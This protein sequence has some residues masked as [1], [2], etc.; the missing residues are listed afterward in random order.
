[1]MIRRL[2]QTS[3]AVLLVAALTGIPSG[4]A[5]LEGET[6]SVALAKREQA[7]RANNLGVA[8]L[9]QFRHKEAAEAFSR[10]LGTDPTLALARINLAI[11]LFNVPDMEAAERGALA[12]IEVAPDAPQAHYVVGLI[13]RQQGKIEEAKAAFQKVLTIDPR[14]V[15]ALVNLGQVQLR[16]RQYEEAVAAFRAAAAA[17]PYNRTAVYNLG[18]ALSRTGSKEESREVMARFLELRKGGYGTEIGRSYPEQGRYAEA[19]TSTGAEPTL[20]DQTT[21]AAR[22]VEAA[23]GALPEHEAPDLAFASAF[24]RQVEAGTAPERVKHDLAAA[25]GGQV[26][27]FDHDGDG[28]LDLF[29]VDARGQ[30]LLR[31]ASGRFS[32]VTRASGLDPS[33]GGIGAVA[34]DHDNDG[35]PDLLVLR[36]GGSTLHRNGDDGRFSDVTAAAG[37][38]PQAGLVVSAAFTDVDHDGDLDIFLAGLASLQRPR[39]R[40]PDDFEATPN[41]L[42]LNDGAGVFTEVAA[43]MGLAG[44]ESHVVA[45]VPM[46]FDNRRDIDLLTVPYGAAPRLF[47]NLRDGTFR[48]VAAEVGLETSARFRC[49]AAADV[50]KDGFTDLF[51]GATEGPDFLALSDGKGRFVMVPAPEGSSGTTAALLLDY[52]NDG[53]LDLLTLSSGGARLL[54]NL[55]AKWVDVSAQALPERTRVPPETSLAAGDIDGDGDTDVVLRFRSGTLRI[56]EN[57]GGNKNPSLRVRIAGRISNR[58]GVGAKVEVRAGSLL[59]RL[60]TYAA[61]PAPAPADIVLG[62]GRRQGADAVRV[63]WPAGILQTELVSGEEAKA[64]SRASLTGPATAR[65]MVVEE[66]DR[67][68]S[69][70]PYLY[71]WNG[72]RFEFVTDFMGGGEIGYWQGPG[73]WSQ[74]DPDEYVRL[75]PGQLSPRDGRFEIRVTNELEEATFLDRVALVVV[76]HPADAQVF[77]NE[78]LTGPP[79]SP[80]RLHVALGARP[81]VSATDHAGRDV[82]DRLTSLDRRYV[83][84]LPVRRVRGYADEHRLTLDLGTAEAGRDLLLLTGWTDYAFSSDNVAAH[85]TGHHL[86]PPTIEVQDAAGQ[87]QAVGTAGIPVGRP[88]TVP[89]DLSGKWLGPGRMVR[90]TTNMRIYWDQILAARPGEPGRAVE[91]TT[92]E[93]SFAELRERGFSLELS[94]DGREPFG[95]DYERATWHSPWKTMPGRYTRLGDVRELLLSSDDMFVISRPGDEVALSFETAALRPLP[96]G[97]ERT[98]LVYADGFSKEMDINSATPHA[99]EPLPFHGMTGYPYTAPEVF[100]WTPERL[101]YMERYNTRV[102]TD[103]LPSLDLA[104]ARARE[105]EVERP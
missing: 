72:Q 81:P 16:E 87:W 8:L 20:V 71:T 64:P 36:P 90:I 11:A 92:L 31:N 38:P 25:L 75:R 55:G 26:M 6:G 68:P 88:Q 2:L 17:E 105:S 56:W 7:Y 39:G 86:L 24:G 48:D 37:I 94:P 84:D 73:V 9:E 74:P 10:S 12:A 85:Q 19:L 95:Y 70:C 98:F 104:I 80:H 18:I 15:G 13:A 49:V 54:R 4:E 78:G 103:P 14:D 66:L 82:L 67:K 57:R 97:W 101:E 30:R 41:R 51:L 96:S 40:F 93:P 35:R 59:H 45:V 52:D 91:S 102:V 61:T 32:D 50:N 46:D 44:G 5:R 62:L 60:E 22:F 23:A 21:P 89:F 33:R 28:D 1:M 3:L 27:L 65:T 100:P 63:L 99:V 47:R 76:T 77:P 83:D 42:L 79:H 29:A 58:S 69:S 34:A 43:R 53:L